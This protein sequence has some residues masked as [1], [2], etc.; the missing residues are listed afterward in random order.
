MGIFLLYAKTKKKEMGLFPYLAGPLLYMLYISGPQSLWL[1][2]LVAA[3]MVEAG[4]RGD[5]S[6]QAV[7]KCTKLHLHKQQACMCSACANGAS[8][9]SAHACSL[10][11]WSFDCSP[12]S[13]TAW[14]LGNP[15]LYYLSN[16]EHSVTKAVV[17]N[18]IFLLQNILIMKIY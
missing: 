3:A 4:R 2:E 7:G 18:F 5:G 11:K 12:I 6:A 14:G 1:C 10:C 8:C 15:D 17:P 9:M 16:Q 13:C